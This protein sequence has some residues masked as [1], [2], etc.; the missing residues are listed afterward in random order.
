[1]KK[2][3][4]QRKPPIAST[5]PRELRFSTGR[6]AGWLVHLVY[7]TDLEWLLVNEQHRPEI[8]EVVRAS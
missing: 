8:L 7:P 2:K 6:W 1:M 3:Q 4:E 5:N